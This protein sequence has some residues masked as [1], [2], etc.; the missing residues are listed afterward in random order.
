A[1]RRDA[2]RPLRVP[3]PQR[4][5]GLSPAL[6]RRGSPEALGLQP[7]LLR[8]PL[9]AAVRVGARA[10]TRLDRAPPPRPRPGRLGAVSDLAP[11]GGVVPLLP[12]A[13]RRAARP[14]RRA[15]ARALGLAPAA[16]RLARRPSRAPSP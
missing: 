8:V 14:G 6:G 5:A 15:P 3:E 16:G 11:H 10:D 12:R 4:V 7:P 2:R 9:R 13:P 1:R